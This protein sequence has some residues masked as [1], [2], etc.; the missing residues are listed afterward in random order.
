MNADQQYWRDQE[1][2]QT[3][4]DLAKLRA[5]IATVTHQRDQARRVAVL[6]RDC[7]EGDRPSTSKY[8]DALKAVE[9]WPVTEEKL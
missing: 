9:S 4:D 6:F 1:E 2:R 8:R 7:S 5:D 3:R